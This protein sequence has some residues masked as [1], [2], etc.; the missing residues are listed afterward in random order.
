[1]STEFPETRADGGKAAGS[2]VHW[3]LNGVNNGQSK[4]DSNLKCL[5]VQSK[6][7]RTLTTNFVFSFTILYMMVKIW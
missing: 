1:M 3:I 4:N 7:P 5:Y 6:V 2:M